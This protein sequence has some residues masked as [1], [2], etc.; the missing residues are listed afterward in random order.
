MFTNPYISAEIA[1]VRHRER[2]A[3][4]EQR[5]LAAQFRGR[6]QAARRMAG[7]TPGWLG[8]LRGVAARRTAMPA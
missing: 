2:L 6:P 1:A 5:R 3:H 4:A 8:A 7:A